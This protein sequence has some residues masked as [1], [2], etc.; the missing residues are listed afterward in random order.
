MSLAGRFIVLSVLALPIA[1]ACTGGQATP[2]PPELAVL[3]PVVPV[4]GDDGRV[5]LAYELRVGAIDPRLALA[6][7][8][9]V[10][11]GPGAEEDA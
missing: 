8:E 4:I 7:L 5:R 1:A 9:V 11:A 3:A 10:P 2:S 6:R